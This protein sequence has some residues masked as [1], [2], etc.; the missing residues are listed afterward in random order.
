[1]NIGTQSHTTSVVVKTFFKS[2]DQDRDLGHEISKPRPRPG[3]SGLETKTETW[4]FRSRDRDRNLDKTNSSAL[5]SRDHGLEITTLHTTVQDASDYRRWQLMRLRYWCATVLFIGVRVR[6]SSPP[7]TP[8]PWRV[9]LPH[10]TH[11]GPPSQQ[12]DLQLRYRLSALDE[13]SFAEW[14]N[15]VRLL[16]RSR[17]FISTNSFKLHMKTPV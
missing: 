11:L 14:K 4:V 3:S 8:S 13:D 5:E 15:L 2:R 16:T 12:F 1:M 10:G 9:W 6:L 17:A 7:E